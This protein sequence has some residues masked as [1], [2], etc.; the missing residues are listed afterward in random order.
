MKPLLLAFAD[1]CGDTSAPSEDERFPIFAV[2][3]CFVQAEL[4]NG[5]V[6]PAINSIKKK[7][8][9]NEEII[10]TS[11]KIRRRTEEFVILNEPALKDDFMK[12]LSSCIESLPITF[13][14]YVLDKRKADPGA[15]SGMYGFA[16]EKCIGMIANLIRKNG[17]SEA[18][19]ELIIEA[20]GNREDRKLRA[21]IIRFMREP[22][23]KDINFKGTEFQRKSSNSVGLQLADLAAYPIASKLLWPER[24]SRAYDTIVGKNG[25]DIT[26]AKKIGLSNFGSP[27]ED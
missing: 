11:R 24:R 12:E 27:T 22:E 19:L 7:Y 2:S 16:M 1:E 9:D 6:I 4:Y 8:F 25:T 21:Q 3:V 14:A 5:D 15:L 26:V 18:P 17:L 20:R 13:F 10:F 23:Y